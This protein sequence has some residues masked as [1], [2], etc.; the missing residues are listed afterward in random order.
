MRTYH[1]SDFLPLEQIVD[2]KRS[3]GD[4]VSLVIPTLNEAATVGSVVGQARRVL[5]EQYP[6]L[7]EILV[8][9]SCSIDSTRD[10]AR[11]AG[12][13]VHL[14][15][16]IGPSL[17]LPEGK[18]TNMWKSLF[19]ARGSVIVFIDADIVGFAPNF[20]YGLVAPLLVERDL[21]WTK[22]FYRR[23]FIAG[24]ESLEG[25]GGRITEILVRP[26]LSA[27]YPEVARVHQP[28]SGEC[29]FRAEA[30][31]AISFASGYGV[32]V[33]LLLNLYRQYGLSRI[34]QVDLDIRRHRNR[35]LDQLG[36]ASMAI[37]RTIMAFLESDGHI[38]MKTPPAERF[39]SQTGESEM[40]GQDVLLP[41]VD[42]FPS[43]CPPTGTP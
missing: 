30:A 28:L 34:G 21:V 5:V 8:I 37:M 6:L 17:E 39:V 40:V 36:H 26:L 12:A 18:G 14:A 32:E 43:Q 41:A 25:Y 33:Q 29:A 1:H 27:W 15:R 24:T 3:S 19:V 23:P 4:S 10:T 11:E 9:D 13:T 38:E 35:P 16:E 42:S 2:R 7:D 20:I 31:R 22:A